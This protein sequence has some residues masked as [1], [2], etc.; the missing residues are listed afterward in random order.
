MPSL[1]DYYGLPDGPEPSGAPTWERCQPINGV[2]PVCPNC[3]AWLC[4]IK[5]C[6][7]SHPLMAGRACTGIYLGCP[8]CPFASPL[9]LSPAPKK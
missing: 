5:V 6:F 4:E 3:G 8:A 7:K 1:R 2:N 9:I